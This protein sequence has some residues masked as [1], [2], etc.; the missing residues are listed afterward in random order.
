MNGA[1]PIAELGCALSEWLVVT[2]PE[3]GHVWCDFRA[4]YRGIRPLALGTLERVTFLQWYGHW[5]D[6]ALASL[7]AGDVVQPVPANRHR[8]KPWWKFW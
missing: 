8:E 2:G 4:D 6:G 1:I 3:A 5:L 7:A